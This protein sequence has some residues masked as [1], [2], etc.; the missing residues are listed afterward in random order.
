MEIG[1]F[2]GFGEKGRVSIAARS[3][4]TCLL[5][6]AG[7]KVGARGADYHPRLVWPAGE[8][9]ALLVSHAH[10]D[11]VGA[12]AWLLAHG[13]RGR[14]LMTAETFREAPV[15]LAGYADPAD[16]AAHPF[17]S[18]RI[19]LFEPGETLSIGGM[20]VETGRSGHVVG[21]VWFAVDD[22]GRCLVH[23]GD[24]VPDSCVFV[25]DPV[26]PCDLI[27]L[28]ASYG[29][30]PVPGKARAK[31]IASWIEARPGG[32]L[33][34]TPLSGRSLELMAIIPGDFAIHAT[35]R[36]ALETQIAAGSAVSPAAAAFLAWRL[37]SA[38]DWT[39]DQ[40]LPALPLLADD[41]MG[42]AGPSARLL[43]RADEE[44]CPV[45]LTGHLPEGSPAKLL[46]EAGRAGWIRMPTHPTLPGSVAIWEGAGRP[47]ALG[48]SCAPADLEALAAHIPS[49]RV[50][51]RTGQVL[52]L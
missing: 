19:E 29:A 5:L 36:E 16:L 50:D 31:A 45:L 28:D 24:V 6:D 43:P 34:P 18:D 13:F 23:C 2:G 46:H 48:H 8:I 12:L 4:G 47:A 37:K 44:G 25:M 21:G 49:L 40:P 52:K 33:L 42:K 51:S 7:I 32:C 26:P 30:D 38:P 11:H 9:D 1:L 35:M 14:I 15:T 39:D 3:R 22:G 41:G 10:E 27:A 17:P 20:T